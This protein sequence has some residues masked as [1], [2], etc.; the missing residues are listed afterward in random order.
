MLTIW[1]RRRGPTPE[2]IRRRELRSF[3]AGTGTGVVL[4]FWLDPELGRSRRRVV[5][6]R[7]WAAVRHGGRRVGRGGR[8]VTLQAVGHAKGALHR[9][10]PGEPAPLDDVGLAHKVESVL[11]RDPRVPKGRISI[12]A[13]S[14][15]V[16]LRG[17]LEDPDLIDDLAARV[18]DIPGVSEVDNLLHLPGT[19]AP[20]PRARSHE[21]AG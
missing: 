7:A 5:R 10:R 16:F 20:H 9:V 14:G 15:T 8:A 3:L 4:A 11:F 19:E 13:E 21:P 18:R 12:N 17:Q 1:R 6:E 2:E